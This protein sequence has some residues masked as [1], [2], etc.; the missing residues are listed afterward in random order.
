LKS[1]QDLYSDLP[2][3]VD[4]IRSY[5]ITVGNGPLPHQGET[6]PSRKPEPPPKTPEPLKAAEPPPKA[7]EPPKAPQQA[8]PTPAAPPQAA[9]GPDLQPPV[10]KPAPVFTQHKPPAELPLSAQQDPMVRHAG[11]LDAAATTVTTEKPTMA[12]HSGADNAST[13]AEP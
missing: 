4:H 2:P 3:S 9:S 10:T 13:S 11:G 6:P 1:G 5:R 8:V 7:S 12:A